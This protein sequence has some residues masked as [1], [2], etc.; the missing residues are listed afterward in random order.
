VNYGYDGVALYGF[1]GPGRKIEIMRQ[2]PNVAMLVDEI[3]K[4]MQWRSVIVEGIFEEL[5]A[6]E[7]RKIG[8]SAITHNGP[9]L[10]TRGLSAESGLVLY[11]IVPEVKSGRFEKYDS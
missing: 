6:P 2:Y 7:E 11:R 5:I 9:H 3:D 4:P 1:S 10:V 8:I